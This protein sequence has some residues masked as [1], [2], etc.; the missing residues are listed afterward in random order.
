MDDD[1]VFWLLV[2][3]TIQ[4]A[5]SHPHISPG[6]NTYDRDHVVVLGPGEERT[7]QQWELELL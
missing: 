2:I 4:H 5:N 6:G 7:S 3:S 1:I